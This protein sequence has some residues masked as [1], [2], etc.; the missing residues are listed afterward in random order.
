MKFALSRTSLMCLLLPLSTA[1]PVFAN[2]LENHAL[3]CL[4]E[5]SMVVNL[6]APEPGQLDSVFVDR[7]D[8][9]NEG[10]FIAMLESQLERSAVNLAEHAVSASAQRELRRRSVDYGL[11]TLERNRTLVKTSSVSKQQLDKIETEYEI[12]VLQLQEQQ[13]SDTRAVLELDRARAALAR[14]TVQSPIGG[15]VVERYKNDGEY[16]EAQP[17]VQIAQLDPL[18][19]TVIAPLSYRDQVEAGTAATVDIELGSR[20]QRIDAT[21]DS[22]DSVADAAS[23]TFGVRLVI[24]NP[25]LALPGGVRCQ[26]QFH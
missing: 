12:A 9:V 22:T 6:S 3:D 24:P 15:V 16:L 2:S 5:P 19:V 7:N 26:V 4:V 18:H 11:R 1:T 23:N 14:R 20:S 21:V 17:I 25:D 10:D 13:E 8:V